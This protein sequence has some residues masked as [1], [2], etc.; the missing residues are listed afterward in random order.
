MRLTSQK[1]KVCFMLRS[2]GQKES[3]EISV[4]NANI[5]GLA[6]SERSHGDISV[7]ATCKSWVDASAECC[8]SFIAVPTPAI[9]HVEWH[10]NSVA[11]FENRN[12]FP[13]LI[14]DSHILVT[15]SFMSTHF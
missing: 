10:D 6:P 8:L 15:C 7:S 4:R 9:R 13:Q 12:S 1:N 11:F 5:L 14:H 3:I 2:W